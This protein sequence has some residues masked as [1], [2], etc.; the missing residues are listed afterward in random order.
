MPHSGQCNR[1]RPPHIELKL[2]DIEKL[3]GRGWPVVVTY[4]TRPHG[5]QPPER[6]SPASRT[7]HVSASLSFSG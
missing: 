1:E 4:H 7:T 6:L 5:S 3:F 2:A